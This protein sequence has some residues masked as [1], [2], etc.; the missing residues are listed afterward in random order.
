MNVSSTDNDMVDLFTIKGKK[1]DG[2]RPEWSPQS[3]GKTPLSQ[4]NWRDGTH[5][6]GN[7]CT[8]ADFLF[9]R[10]LIV[11]YSDVHIKSDTIRSVANEQL[12]FSA[13]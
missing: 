3:S 8:S 11:L 10:T 7:W 12:I 9:L 4:R 13:V 6:G 2:T 5:M 1:R